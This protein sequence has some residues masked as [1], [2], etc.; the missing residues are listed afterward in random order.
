MASYQHQMCSF[1]FMKS[2]IKV[3]FVWLMH[4][5]IFWSDP[6]GQPL[7]GDNLHSW[8]KIS[9]NFRKH[10]EFYV[11]LYTFTKIKVDVL[12][13]YFAPFIS[14]SNQEIQKWEKVS[15]KAF[16]ERSLVSVFDICYRF[17][18]I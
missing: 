17:K 13:T 7:V 16:L 2:F 6:I 12:T 10:F 4:K 1:K 11:V 14:I 9:E 5:V 18:I 15:L 3:I 8:T